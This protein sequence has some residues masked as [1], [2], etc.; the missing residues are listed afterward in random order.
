MYAGRIVEHARTK[1]LLSN[2]LHPYTQGLIRCMPRLSDDKRELEAIPG[3]VPHP[4]RFPPGCRFHPR[5]HRSMELAV[6]D[7]RT[8]VEVESHIGGPVLRRCVEQCDDEP[9]GVPQLRELAPHHFVACWEA[10]K[11]GVGSLRRSGGRD[12]TV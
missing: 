5:C 2:P 8:A 6:T 7:G 10:E 12:S 9:S 1:D 3:S 11:E 4:T